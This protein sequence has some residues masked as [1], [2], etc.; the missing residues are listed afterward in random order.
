MRQSGGQTLYL[1]NNRGS[2]QDYEFLACK[3]IHK[4]NISEKDMKV[5]ENA[6]TN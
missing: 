4:K 5:I 3:V 2:F 1:S 6:I